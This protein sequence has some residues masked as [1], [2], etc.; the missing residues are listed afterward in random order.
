MCEA[1]KTYSVLEMLVILA[2]IID[3]KMDPNTEWEIGDEY[4]TVGEILNRAEIVIK[5]GTSQ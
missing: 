4:T 2:E 5:R 1:A 3:W